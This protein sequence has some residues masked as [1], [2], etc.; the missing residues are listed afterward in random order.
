MMNRLLR[1]ITAVCIGTCLTQ[2]LLLAYFTVQGTLNP[3]TGT[4]VIALLH[5]I[6]IT[7]ERLQR[8]LRENDD[9]EQPSFDEVLETR[10]RDNLD[11]DM[12]LRSQNRFR[13][14]LS[15]MLAKLMTERERFDERRD[16]FDRNLQ[17]LEEG[18]VDEGL[19]QVQRLMQEL[20]AEKAKD[21]LK[22]SFD[23]QRIDDVVNIV[24]AIPTDTRK[25]ILAEF[26]SND[27]NDMLYQII[28]RI[29]EGLPVTS[30]IEQARD[31]N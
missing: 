9:G 4:K 25:D 12:R 3:M 17:E 21:M 28:R 2:M 27:E 31:G 23:D 13:S 29:G 26:D 22:R 20:E 1:A 16:A 14:E 18:A 6:D 7:G 8:I 10:R 19:V 15:E 30:L 5:G 24:Q 11:M